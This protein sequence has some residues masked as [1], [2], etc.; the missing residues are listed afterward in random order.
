VIEAC[1]LPMG[2]VQIE[3]GAPAWYHPGRSGTIKMG[4]KVVLGTFGEFH[5]KALG[6]LDVS[7]ALCGF[8][9][10]VDAMPEPKKKATRTK[11]A[12]DLSPFQAVKRDFAFVVDKTVDAGAIV[13]AAMGAD[14]KLI[15]SVNVFDLFEGASVG[16][17]KKSIAIEVVIQ[18][19]DKTLTDEDFEALTAKIVGNVVKSTGGALRA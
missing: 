6:A 17:G 19:T 18:P 10:F 13:R 1:G 4:P 5:P 12:L 2:N 16:E 11:P 15:S 8:E 7:G 14:R 9:I 3:A